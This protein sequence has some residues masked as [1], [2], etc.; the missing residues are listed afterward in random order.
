M[1]NE[2]KVVRITEERTLDGQGR[3]VKQHRVDWMCGENGPF[4]LYVP[5]AFADPHGLRAELDK[6]AAQLAVITG[7]SY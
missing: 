3:P 7:P 2:V 1:A 4:T 6:R 5:D